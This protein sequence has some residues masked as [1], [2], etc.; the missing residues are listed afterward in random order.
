[1]RSSCLAGWTL[2]LSLISLAAAV[3][4]D[5]KADKK[6]DK[7]PEPRLS[8]SNLSGLELRTIGRSYDREPGIGRSQ[9]KRGASSIRR[10][11]PRR[12]LGAPSHHG[13]PRVASAP[14]HNLIS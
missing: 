3:A 9:M 6:D 7:K 8:A 11:A 14:V 10:V 4:A 2:A 5:K 13:H 1:M 12:C